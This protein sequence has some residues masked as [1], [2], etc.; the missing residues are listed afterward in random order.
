M[1][2]PLLWV[3]V[4]FLRR[5]VGLSDR[6]GHR[7]QL[8]GRGEGEELP[9]E[10]NWKSRRSLS[11]FEISDN[12]EELAPWSISKSEWDRGH[13]LAVANA[14]PVWHYAFGTVVW[15]TV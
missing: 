10:E 14:R 9:P 8:I 6:K 3:R 11:H 15:R 1:N 5:V 2:A 13:V 4:R 7:D 12:C